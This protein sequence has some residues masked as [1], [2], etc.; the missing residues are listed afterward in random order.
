[1]SQEWSGRHIE[2]LVVHL[3]IVIL[4]S[5]A[6]ESDLYLKAAVSK[7]FRIIKS[8]RDPPSP[9]ALSGHVATTN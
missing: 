4:H 9:D 8:W 3:T 5:G 7:S 6:A 2:V 1:M